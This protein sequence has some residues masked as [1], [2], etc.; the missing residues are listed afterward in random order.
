MLWV[1]AC[2]HTASAKPLTPENEIIITSFLSN[3]NDGSS[4][5][6]AS[7]A[8]KLDRSSGTN[9]DFSC[10]HWDTDVDVLMLGL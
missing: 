2:A 7:G 5:T 3:N 10:R 9:S 1:Q 6:I 4:V 8:V